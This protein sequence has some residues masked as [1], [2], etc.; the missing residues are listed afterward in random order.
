MQGKAAGGRVFEVMKRQPAIDLDAQ[1]RRG[2]G[3]RGAV[4]FGLL[5]LLARGCSCNC[6]VRLATD[7]SLMHPAPPVQARR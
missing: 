3:G 5:Q 1:G 6:A 4:H 7:S 2:G